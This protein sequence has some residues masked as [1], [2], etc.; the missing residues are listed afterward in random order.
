MTDGNRHYEMK[1]AVRVVGGFR[2]F[3][4]RV[5]LGPREYA[6]GEP[7]QTIRDACQGMLFEQLRRNGYKPSA[8]TYAGPYRADGK[9]R[10]TLDKVA[11]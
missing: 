9:A 1:A 3:T 10:G 2:Y 8:A 5:S 6:K 11:T 7:W 4:A